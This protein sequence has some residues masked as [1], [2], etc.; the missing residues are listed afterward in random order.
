MIEQ[1]PE[2]GEPG[3]KVTGDILRWPLR[4]RLAEGLTMLG[5]IVNVVSMALIS[6][7]SISIILNGGVGD[8]NAETFPLI[9]GFGYVFGAG[10]VLGMIM[11]G[12]GKV[13][14]SF[15]DR[16]QKK[17]LSGDTTGIEERLSADDLEN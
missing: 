4:R 11:F 15:I 14:S 16:N 2:R 10:L 5:E 9:M 3:P 12:S 7:W 17:L 8:P 6:G 13:L 1:K